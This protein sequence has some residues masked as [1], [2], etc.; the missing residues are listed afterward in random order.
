LQRL[1]DRI[2]AAQKNT[3]DENVNKEGKS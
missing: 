1:A 2:A 3:S